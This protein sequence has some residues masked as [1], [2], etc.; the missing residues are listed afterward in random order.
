MRIQEELACMRSAG[1]MR[2]LGKQYD[3]TEDDVDY[4]VFKF[5]TTPL[6]ITMMIPSTYPDAPPRFRL[7]TYFPLHD[8]LVSQLLLSNTANIPIDIILSIFTYIGTTTHEIPL[9]DK[10]VEEWA[11]NCSL[12][13]LFEAIEHEFVTHRD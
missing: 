10:I 13:H 6:S 9:F 2:Q 7:C 11:F 8:E 5:M 12:K 4:H 3:V 1:C